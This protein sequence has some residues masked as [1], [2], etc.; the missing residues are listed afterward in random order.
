MCVHVAT[1]TVQPLASTAV[2]FPP[3]GCLNDGVCI[4]PGHCSCAAHWSGLACDE[5]KYAIAKL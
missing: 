4:R 5:G 1:L 2:C 3:S